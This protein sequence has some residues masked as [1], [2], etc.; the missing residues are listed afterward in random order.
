MVQNEKGEV[1]LGRSEFGLLIEN[2]DSPADTSSVEI[3]DSF[4]RKERELFD[5]YRKRKR[6]RRIS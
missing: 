6:A 5:K 4:Y 3:P 1:I 2:D